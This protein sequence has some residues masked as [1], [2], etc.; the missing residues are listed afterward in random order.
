ME[1]ISNECLQN[2]DCCNK[3]MS[4][5]NT[6]YPMGT[7]HTSNIMSRKEKE[8]IYSPVNYNPKE[9]YSNRSVLCEFLKAWHHG[10]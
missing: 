3:V 1:K 5:R 7:V 9:L 2:D 10:L 8:I 6:G 4:D